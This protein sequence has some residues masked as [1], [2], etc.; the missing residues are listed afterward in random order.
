M[1]FKNKLVIFF[2]GILLVVSDG[3]GMEVEKK[4]ENV[5]I[6]YEL[7]ALPYLAANAFWNERAKRELYMPSS[8]PDDCFVL[9]V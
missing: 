3:R 7:T 5:A 9:L 2:A 8:F 6:V 4:E 1:F